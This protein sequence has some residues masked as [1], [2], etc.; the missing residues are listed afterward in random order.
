MWAKVHRFGKYNGCVAC[1]FRGGRERL[2]PATARTPG[3]CTRNPNPNDVTPT[4]SARK[5]G[6]SEWRNEATT[7]V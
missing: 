6:S 2:L 1:S 4:G 5:L 3:Y 7:A